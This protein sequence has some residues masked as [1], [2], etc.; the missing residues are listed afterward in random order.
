[1]IIRNKGR[2]AVVKGKSSDEASDRTYFEISLSVGCSKKALI[3]LQC[4]SYN[5]FPV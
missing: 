4:N 1:M 5:L 3:D 2:T